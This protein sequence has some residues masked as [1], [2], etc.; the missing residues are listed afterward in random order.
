VVAL[1]TSY[2][3]ARLSV[4]YPSTGGTVEFLNQAFGSGLTTG[5]LNI[6]LWISYMVML[7]LYASAFGSYGASFFPATYQ[8]LV[9]H[10]LITGVI[11]VFTLINVLG[12]SAVGDSE[13]WIVLIKVI[14]LLLFIGA[15]FWTIN[16]H[17]LAV[18][19]WTPLPRLV[20]GGMI[21]F[22]A[23]EGF[24]LI[25]NAGGNLAHPESLLPRA[26]YLSVIFVI[27]L[28]LAIAAVT[29]G[30]LPLED[31]IRHKDYALAVSARPFLGKAGF[32]LIAVAALLST[33]SAINATLYG[34]ARI[35]YV[36]AK[37]GEL[38]RVLE[39]KIWRRPLEGLF[40]T[41]GMALLM[42]N[43][44]DIERI[45]MMGS[46]GFLLI[47]AGVNAANWHLSALTES[48]RW[49]AGAGLVACLGALAGLI[50]QQLTTNPREIFVLII[51]VVISFVLEALY[52]AITKRDIIP[53]F[54]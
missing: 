2:S 19:N 36:I 51:M 34:A 32:S 22:L 24:E 38:P 40:L 45:S 41:T 12:S 39:R 21:I 52:R 11:L 16:P 29:V 23:Y 5:T 43:F 44:F 15:G 35:S 30:N 54:K 3:Y 17:R 6:L 10:G 48:S 25:A 9:K 49:L 27:L 8:L 26:Y 53:F 33:A 18:S 31:I 37:D 50:W 13:Q 42:A 20:A 4:K 1:L 14:I 7:A 47:F 46:A 28:Y